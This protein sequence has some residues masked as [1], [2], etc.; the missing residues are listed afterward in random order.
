MDLTHRLSFSCEGK[1]NYNSEASH[2]IFCFSRLVSPTYLLLL[3]PWMYVLHSPPL[4]PTAPD[5]H[6]FILCLCSLLVSICE[7]DRVI[8][9][10]CAWL[11]S[12]RS[13]HVGKIEESPFEAENIPLSLSTMFSLSAH[14]QG[15]KLFLSLV[16]CGWRYYKH[17]TQVSLRAVFSPQWAIFYFNFN[18]LESTIYTT[19]HYGFRSVHPT[20]TI[21]ICPFLYMFGHIIF[22]CL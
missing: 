19:F 8:F 9:C 3:Y 22:I 17:R 16:Y 14:Q 21:A 1:W 15:P 13:I 5:S 10:F 18:F 20:N 7:W 12:F 2:I 11:L 6:Y 4:L